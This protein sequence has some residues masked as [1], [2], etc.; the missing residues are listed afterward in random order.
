MQ[1]ETEVSSES[2][3]FSHPTVISKLVDIHQ[4]LTFLG[5]LAECK[6]GSEARVDMGGG[7][8]IIGSIS[9]VVRYLT[10]LELESGAT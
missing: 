3:Q 2:T 4:V 6:A 10:K 5:V 1:F 8:K 9:D 7:V